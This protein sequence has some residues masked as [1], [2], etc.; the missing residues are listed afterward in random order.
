MPG[1][2]GKFLCVVPPNTLRVDV[3]SGRATRSGPVDGL[4]EALD[5]LEFKTSRSTL[6]GGGVAIGVGPGIQ[7]FTDNELIV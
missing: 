2:V 4:E 1:R 7:A 6:D 5:A 3:E